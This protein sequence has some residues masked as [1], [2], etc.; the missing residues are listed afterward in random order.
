MRLYE[1]YDEMTS[2]T[3]NNNFPLPSAGEG[4]LPKLR[5]SRV[6]ALPDYFRVVGH[7]FFTKVGDMMMPVSILGK[8]REMIRIDGILVCKLISDVIGIYEHNKECL[9]QPEFILRSEDL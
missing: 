8:S 4:K 6:R 5:R 7:G 1:L 2:Q 3:D 9:T